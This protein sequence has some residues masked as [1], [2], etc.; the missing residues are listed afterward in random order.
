MLMLLL[1]VGSQQVHLELRVALLSCLPKV[2]S[3]FPASGGEAGS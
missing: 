2:S 1:D 3:F